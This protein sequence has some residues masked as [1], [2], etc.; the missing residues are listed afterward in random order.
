MASPKN[1]KD[2]DKEKEKQ[3]NVMDEPVSRR[4]WRKHQSNKSFYEDHSSLKDEFKTSET[5][6]KS[7]QN[8]NNNT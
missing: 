4:D 2:K 1:K 7:S 3:A 6:T 5:C 8:E